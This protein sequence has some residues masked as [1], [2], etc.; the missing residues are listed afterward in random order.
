MDNRLS[1]L[2]SQRPTSLKREDLPN[3]A[4]ALVSL[5]RGEAS[6]HTGSAN[7]LG[8]VHIK[9]LNVEVQI[10]S[11]DWARID[12]ILATDS[13]RKPIKVVSNSLRTEDV[14]YYQVIYHQLCLAF[15]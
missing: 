5:F 7:N 13:F 4:K 3:L 1:S 11:E 12:K 6:L 10:L 2:K 14:E 9:G 8:Y 15:P